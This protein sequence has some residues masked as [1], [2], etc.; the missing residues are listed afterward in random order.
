M[1]ASLLMQLYSQEVVE[2]CERE[3]EKNQES[4][5]LIFPLPLICHVTLEKAILIYKKVLY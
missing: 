1:V 3:K 5:A 4:Y 2:M